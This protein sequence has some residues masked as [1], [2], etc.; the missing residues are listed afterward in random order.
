[1]RFILVCINTQ[2]IPIY[3]TQLVLET[4]EVAKIKEKYIISF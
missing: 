4:N 2:Y 3:N 1:M